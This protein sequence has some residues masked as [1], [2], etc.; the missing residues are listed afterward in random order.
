[1]R[2]RL[3]LG[4]VAVFALLVVPVAMAESSDPGGPQATAS[5]SVKKKVKKLKGQVK[6]LSQRLVALE[7]E[8]ADQGEGENGA[9]APPS[10]RKSV[11]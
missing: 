8:L 4:A 10:D 11:V 6:T 1:M 9:T 2:S 3:S 5:G 7:R